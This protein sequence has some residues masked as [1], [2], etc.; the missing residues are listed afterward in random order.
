[1]NQMLAHRGPDD[2]GQWLDQ[3]AG[4][5]LANRRLAIIDLSPQGAQPMTNED[6]SLRLVYNGEIYNYRELRQELLAKG[7]R[8]RSETDTEVILNLYAE[9]GEGLFS[10]LNG[11]FAL[12]L[13][14]ARRNQLLVA[15][16]GMGVKPLYY[17]QTK[18]GILF[19]SELKAL[20]LCPQV[21]TEIDPLTVHYH[22]AYL[23][24]PAPNTMLK[25]VR[26]LPPGHAMIIRGGQVV[27]EWQ[28]YD[29]PYNGQ[30][31]SGGEVEIAAELRSKLEQAVS[32]Q[33]V[34]DVPVGAMFS[35]GLDSSTVVAMMR[36]SRPDL[37]PRCYTIGFEGAEDL[38]GT[39]QDL[40]YA[41][42]VAR[43]LDVE[44]VPITVGP[45]IIGHLD[46]M[47]HHLDEPQADPAP[48]NALLIA[49]QARRDGIKVL[50]SGTGGDDIFSGYR[51]HWAIKMER[52]WGWLP[53]A[54]RRG[55]AIWA[56]QGSGQ[57][58]RQRR[59]H[60]VLSYADQPPED[61]LISYFY[62][63]S[64][65]TRRALYSPDLSQEL[66]GVDTAA[67]LR[68][69]LGNIPAERDRLQRMLYLEGKHFLPDHNLNYLDKTG[70]AAGVEIRVPLLDLELINFAVGIPPEMKYRGVTSKYI[71]KKAMAPLLPREAIYRPKTGFGAPLRR[72]LNRELREM[73][74]E[75]LSARALENR[76]LFD[77]QAVRNLITLNQQGK[78]DAAYTIFALLCLEL[79]CRR[80][81]DRPMEVMVGI[82]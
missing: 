17:S 23:W 5:G 13:W 63:S 56:N 73:L 19:A 3:A 78:V 82:P 64:E 52:T 24:A 11:I 53:L 51:R 37:R 6:G 43:A 30:R 72:W 32:R 10:R 35:G 48:I 31:L 47:L 45:D 76:G 44:L 70:M 69:S 36:R 71:L 27:R 50:L 68:A 60:R 8:F 65:Q 66:D 49:E 77:P 33:M 21:S 46:R 67:P 16:D 61:R 42:R 54:I 26:K 59:L 29:L 79:W 2:S 58:V 57:G 20:R 39:P 4:V 7:H 74:E 9:M 40:P 41:R 22:L 25:D 62:W 38:D 14:D 12:A 75:V 34:S 28:H 80:F 18:S 55:L 81:V 1:M 15:R